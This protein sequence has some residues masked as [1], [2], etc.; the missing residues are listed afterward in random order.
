MK[1]TKINLDRP[2][3][4]SE[5]IEKKQDFNKIVKGLI[6]RK[7]GIYRNPWFYGFVGA[8]SL[9]TFFA[10]REFVNTDSAV[11]NKPIAQV[12]SAATQYFDPIG[13][14]DENTSPKSDTYALL[15]AENETTEKSQTNETNSLMV[16]STLVTGSTLESKKK[17]GTVVK[18][19]IKVPNIGG[20][21]SG[22]MKA[23]ELLKHSII[24]S[25][26]TEPIKSFMIGYFNGTTDVLE[27]VSG[28]ELSEKLKK[29]IIEFNTGE[30]I[31][32]TEM[33]VN[34]SEG[35]LVMLSPINLRILKD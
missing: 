18:K 23:S 2:K 9:I 34:D 19:T 6:I 12:Q 7:P 28:N 11:K 25:G 13:R 10:I 31:F 26:T 17:I 35:K 8:S 30:M 3:I 20:V 5:E 32:F 33:Y 22:S 27:F 1:T 16:Q 4:S 14:K 21:H 15:M 29:N 24:E